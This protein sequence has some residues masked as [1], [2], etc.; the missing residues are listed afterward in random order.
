MFVYDITAVFAHFMHSS[1]ATIGGISAVINAST[2][3]GV[4]ACIPAVRQS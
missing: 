4:A 1:L 2:S 3:C